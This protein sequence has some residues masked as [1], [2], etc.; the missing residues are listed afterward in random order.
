[1]VRFVHVVYLSVVVFID[2]YYSLH[3]YTTICLSIFLSKDIWVV[4]SF[5]YC[6]YNF[7]AHRG[8]SLFGYMFSL[9]SGYNKEWNGC[10]KG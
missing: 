8:A 2:Q 10:V 9:L 6:V 4:T 1:M 5:E 7:Y 3:E